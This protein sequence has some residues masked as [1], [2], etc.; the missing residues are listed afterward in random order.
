M[1]PNYEKSEIEVNLSAP[2]CLKLK[3]LYFPDKPWVNCHNEIS[4]KFTELKQKAMKFYIDKTKMEV[5]KELLKYS[6]EDL[7]EIL[8][9]K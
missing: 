2:L 3:E 4:V 8:L 6:K 1:K 9:H 7:Q 5:L